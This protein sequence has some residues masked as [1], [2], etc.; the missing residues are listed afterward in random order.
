L[1]FNNIFIYIYKTSNI[2]YKLVKWIAFRNFKQ[3][4]FTI[5]NLAEDLTENSITDSFD[6]ITKTIDKNIE[7][8]LNKLTNNFF[9]RKSI[10]GISIAF[11]LIITILPIIFT[12]NNEV[13]ESYLLLYEKILIY[14]F[15]F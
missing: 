13:F 10:Y 5:K 11:Y 1:Y 15:S 14:I 4:Y 9:F 8:T 7:E 2:F 12:I 6:N 3:L